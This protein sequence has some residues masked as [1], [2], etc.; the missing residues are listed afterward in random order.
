MMN[1]WYIFLINVKFI[2]HPIRGFKLPK[3]RAVGQTLA[4]WFR[5]SSMLQQCTANLR[6]HQPWCMVDKG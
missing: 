4:L 5:F 6:V 2:N 1:G 3:Y